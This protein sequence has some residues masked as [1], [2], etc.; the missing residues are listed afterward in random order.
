M[1]K[2]G[3]HSFMVT[4][5]FC[6]LFVTVMGNFRSAGITCSWFDENLTVETPVIYMDTSYKPAEYLPY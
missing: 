6:Y 2:L 5:A 1:E 4:E 3:N